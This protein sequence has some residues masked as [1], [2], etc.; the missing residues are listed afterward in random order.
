MADGEKPNSTVTRTRD[1]FHRIKWQWNWSNTLTFVQ[2]STSCS[3]GHV[4]VGK[5]HILAVY[6]CE[7]FLCENLDL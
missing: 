3:V 1:I 6:N 7:I 5:F 2:Q 4:M